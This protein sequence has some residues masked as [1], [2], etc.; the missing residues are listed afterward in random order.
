M[1]SPRM[2]GHA[3]PPWPVHLH[4]RPAAATLRRLLHWG[5]RGVHHHPLRPGLH[6]LPGRGLPEGEGAPAPRSPSP[7]PLSMA[8]W[9][10]L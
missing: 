2:P 4:R 9:G 7:V 6:R 5:T 1:L 8:A 10:Q 3:E